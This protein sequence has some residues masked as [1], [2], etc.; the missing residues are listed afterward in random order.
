MNE[1]KLGIDDIA[2]NDYLDKEG[3]LNFRE[4]IRYTDNMEPVDDIYCT[5]VINGNIVRLTLTEIIEEAKNN[6]ALADLVFKVTSKMKSN[7]NM[8]SNPFKN[9]S[10]DSLTGS[11]DGYVMKSIRDMSFYGR[12]KKEDEGLLY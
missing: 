11:D 8:R 10:D 1:H 9:R 2:N 3:E 5:K 4:Y 7:V 6:Q 12:E